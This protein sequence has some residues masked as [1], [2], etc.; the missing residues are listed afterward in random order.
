MSLYQEYEKAH[1][2]SRLLLCG[3]RF[4]TTILAI[5]LAVTLV[6]GTAFQ[7]FA[8]DDRYNIPGES[9]L[10]YYSNP[11]CGCDPDWHST[12]GCCLATGAAMIFTEMVKGLNLWAADPDLENE[13]YI[14][15]V[16]DQYLYPALQKSSDALRSAIVMNGVLYAALI[17]GQNV[18]Q[19][20]TAL[21]DEN[22]NTLKE[23]NPGTQLCRFGTLSRSLASSQSNAEV[24][25]LALATK[26][27]HRQLL[28]EQM[29]SGNAVGPG[30]TLGRSADKLKRAEQYRTKFCDKGDSNTAQNS[31]TSCNTTSDVQSNRDID[32]TRT[33]DAPLTLDISFAGAPGTLTNDEENILA[34]DSNLYAHDLATNIGKSDLNMARDGNADEITRKLID[35]RAIAAKRSVA[36]NSFAAITGMKAAGSTAASSY[37]KEVVKEIGITDAGELD[38]YLGTN[39]S[40][41]AQMEVLSKKLYQNPAFYSGL[42]VSDANVTRAQ[43]AMAGIESMQERD[44]YESLARSEML[45]SQI[46]EIQVMREQDNFTNK[47]QK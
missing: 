34:L 44:I 1:L 35:F 30:T 10:V 33:L 38:K 15:I 22:A 42:I 25:Q 6:T 36:Q 7:A 20:L 27:Q 13:Y 4:V 31:A 39:P 40:Y 12:G 14:D 21:Q 8:S 9:G 28:R 5:T 41:Y 29:A 37:I 43:A 32:V 47:S 11:Y 46:L 45:L 23:Y 2:A 24:T 17:D 3:R 19:T 18:M 26:A 16:Y